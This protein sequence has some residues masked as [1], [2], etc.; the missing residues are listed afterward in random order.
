MI[1]IITVAL[2]LPAIVILVMNVIFSGDLSSELLGIALTLLCLD[3]MRMA[4]VDLQNV[5]AIPGLKSD[6]RLTWFYRVTLTTIAVELFGFYLAGWYLGVGAIV[7]LLSQ[8]GF[9]L[10][11][12]IQLEPS[13]EQPIIT[14]TWRDRLVVLIA[15]G[16]GIGLVSFW[17]AKMAMLGMSIGLLLM[18]LVYGVVKYASAK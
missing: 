1:V 17:L 12:G 9:N 13:A 2:F 4:I 7:V 18:V 6:D 5:R 14:W 3:Q 10:F 15:D 16:V 11:A 8:I